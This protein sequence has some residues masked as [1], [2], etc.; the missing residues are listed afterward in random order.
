MLLTIV[1]VQ[2]NYW[3]FYFKS[4]V[5]QVFVSL[6]YCISHGFYTGM[7]SF[8]YFISTNRELRIGQKFYCHFNLTPTDPDLFHLLF[9]GI[10]SSC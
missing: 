2:S 3:V 4:G 10:A 8:R 7:T 6:W 1:T 5:H 9:L